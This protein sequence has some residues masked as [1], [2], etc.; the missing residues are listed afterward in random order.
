MIRFDLILKKSKIAFNIEML[1]KD[2]GNMTVEV[3]FKDPIPYRIL[4]DHI[5]EKSWGKNKPE[6]STSI[7]KDGTSFKLTMY[8][9]DYD[10]V[11]KT[12]DEILMAVDE[13]HVKIKKM[14]KDFKKHFKT[15]FA[16]KK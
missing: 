5:Q 3:G 1:D 12:I 9:S 2:G 4:K 6:Y 15:K 14:R 16:K 13:D 7:A 11:Q 8:D 10:R